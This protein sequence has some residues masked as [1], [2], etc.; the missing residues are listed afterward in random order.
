[1]IADQHKRSGSEIYEVWYRFG[2]LDKDL[3]AAHLVLVVIHVDGAEDVKD[4]LLLWTPPARPRLSGQDGVPGH[5]GHTGQPRVPLM[6]DA[7]IEMDKSSP[8]RPRTPLTS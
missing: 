5:G 6:V 4:P 3:G 2:V 8:E 7:G 1:M